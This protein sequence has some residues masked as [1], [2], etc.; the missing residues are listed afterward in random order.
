MPGGQQKVC[1]HMLQAPHR[2]SACRPSW[3][4]IKRQI[5][6]AGWVELPAI[7]LRWSL[8]WSNFFL[9]LLVNRKNNNVRSMNRQYVRDE[10]PLVSC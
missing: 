10:L 9:T 7:Q 2:P 6:R 1:T 8:D 5:L 3:R 4:S